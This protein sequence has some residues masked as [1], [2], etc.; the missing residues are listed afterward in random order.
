MGENSSLV[1]FVAP[2]PPG[3][4][5]RC[6]A[7]RAR[8]LHRQHHAAAPGGMPFIGIALDSNSG[9]CSQMALLGRRTANT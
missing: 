1:R 8:L 3:R 2:S 7:G 9:L 6:H 4:P 5:F